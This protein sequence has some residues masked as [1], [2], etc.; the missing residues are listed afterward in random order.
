MWSWNMGLMRWCTCG[1]ETMMSILDMQ[2]LMLTQKFQIPPWP[3]RAIFTDFGSK[4]L[5][6]SLSVSRRAGKPIIS[7]L[8]H[9]SNYETRPLDRTSHVPNLVVLNTLAS[10]SIMVVCKYYKT[11]CLLSELCHPH[12]YLQYIKTGDALFRIGYRWY[13]SKVSRS[14]GTDDDPIIKSSRSSSQWRLL[15]ETHVWVV[16]VRLISRKSHLSS[17]MECSHDWYSHPR[18]Y[19][20][21][22][23]W[24]RTDSANEGNPT[25]FNLGDGYDYGQGEK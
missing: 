18:Q 1:D 2:P 16:V 15:M 4:P 9:P 3:N 20:I 6:E 7:V 13:S 14:H 17:S 8:E 19:S 11:E 24:H 21:Q 22:P 5:S 12:L 10:C 23:D 25:S